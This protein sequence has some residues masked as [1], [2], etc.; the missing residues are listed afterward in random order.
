MNLK[1]LKKNIKKVK[2]SHLK[3]EA[4]TGK[5][6]NALLATCLS[7]CSKIETL[8]CSQGILESKVK[9]VELK[10]ISDNPNKF[11]NP[12]DDMFKQYGD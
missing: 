9:T 6:I 10:S 11:S 8:Q 1:E 4:D 5:V 12:F 7:M 2:D 3:G